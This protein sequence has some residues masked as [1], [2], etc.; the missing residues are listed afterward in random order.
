MGGPLVQRHWIIVSP[1]AIDENPGG[2]LELVAAAAHEPIHGHD[3]AFYESVARHRLSTVLG[4]GGVH[5]AIAPANPFDMVEGA[6]ID[7]DHAFIKSTGRFA[8]VSTAEFARQAYLFDVDGRV[9]RGAGAVFKVLSLCPRRRWMLRC[10]E[11]LPGG[12]LLCDA[13][14]GLVAGNRACVSR[15]FL[16]AR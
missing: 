13:V 3:P 8:G 7:V 12:R 1:T 5:G 15:F 10:Y 16:R 9:Y 2:C 14:Y 4:A 6:S 11:R